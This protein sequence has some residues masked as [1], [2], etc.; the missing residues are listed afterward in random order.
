MFSALKVDAVSTSTRQFL[1]HILEETL[2]FY[3]R[4][5]FVSI[6]GSNYSH[7]RDILRAFYFCVDPWL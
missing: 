6:P 1:R 5:I 7:M 4:F 2:Y 3:G